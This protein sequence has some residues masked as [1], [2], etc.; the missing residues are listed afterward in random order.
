MIFYITDNV[1]G[2]LLIIFQLNHV[3]L[4]IFFPLISNIDCGEP[5]CFKLNHLEKTCESENGT[6]QYGDQQK[7]GPYGGKETMRGLRK[8]NKAYWMTHG[9]NV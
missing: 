4:I 2:D 6:L 5:F 8:L 1:S 7:I 3:F 9:G